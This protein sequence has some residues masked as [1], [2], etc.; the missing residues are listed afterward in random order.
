MPTHWRLPLFSLVLLLACLFALTADTVRSMVTVWQAATTYHHCFLVLPI[1]IF[2]IWRK[3]GELKSLPPEHTAL[4]YLP[5]I[6]FAFLW[7][8]G[9][10]G[11]I[12]LF[13]HLALVG[14]AVSIVIALLGWRI[15]RLIAFP[16]GF[17]VFLVPFGDGLVPPLQQFTATFAVSLLRLIDIPVFHDGIMI[18]TP[19]GLFEVAEACAGIRFLI[20]NIMIGALFA[21]LALRRPWKWLLFLSLAII[22]P[23]IAN[24]FRA[25]GI[26]LI[27]Y[28]TNNEYAAGVDHLV[29]GWGFFAVVMLVFLAIGQAMADGPA[30]TGKTVDAVSSTPVAGAWNLAYALPLALVVMAAPLYARTVLERGPGD[31]AIDPKLML[32]PTLALDLGPVCKPDHQGS[33]TWRPRFDRADMTQGLI[34]DCGGKPVDLFL[35]YYAFERDGV[36]LIHHANRLADGDNWTRTATSWHAT[37]V[38]GL[39]STVRAE[40]LYGRE[41]GDRGGSRLVLDRRPIAFEGLAGQGLS[42]LPATAWR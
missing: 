27:A 23:I 34:I 39:P 25:F 8:I 10:A 30:S 16:L 22:I 28:L 11:H 15:A 32:D 33:E 35:A 20:A 42:A 13:E 1:G 9:R 6:G 29:Y 12:Q 17:L 2:L 21:Y 7:L 14:M 26:I 38:D 36:E 18:E 24:G 19:S 4:A 40:D 31:I 41:A 3:R 37:N 5:L